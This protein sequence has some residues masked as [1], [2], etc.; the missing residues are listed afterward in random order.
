MH[1]S[2]WEKSWCLW[3]SVVF[4]GLWSSATVPVVWLKTVTFLI[5]M[6]YLENGTINKN[7]AHDLWHYFNW[8]C[9]YHLVYPDIITMIFSGLPRGVLGVRTHPLRMLS[10]LVSN[11]KS[12]FCPLFHFKIIMLLRVFYNFTK[13]LLNVI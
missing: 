11:V 3:C 9:Y 4:C 1:H 10:A 6:S 5:L 12:L 13:F 2:R 8:T 7:P